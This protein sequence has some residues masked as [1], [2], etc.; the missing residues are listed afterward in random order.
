MLD[1]LKVILVIP[2]MHKVSGLENPQRKA[3][4]ALARRIKNGGGEEALAA[5]LP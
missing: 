4:A 3:P 1:P 5:L 2:T